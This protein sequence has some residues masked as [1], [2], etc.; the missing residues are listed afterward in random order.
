[1]T[2]QVL[3]K[4]T[5]MATLGLTLCLAYLKLDRFRYRQ[6]IQGRVQ[7]IL[8]KLQ[9]PQE[10]I[11]EPCEDTVYHLALNLLANWSNQQEF[12]KIKNSM[13]ERVKYRSLFGWQIVLYRVLFEPP[14]PRST[15]S[16]PN[17]R[18]LGCPGLDR[19]VVTLL[20]FFSLV[21]F[22]FGMAHHFIIGWDILAYV[23]DDR[24][25]FAWWIILLICILFPIIFAPIGDFALRGI[26]RDIE[27]IDAEVEK[28]SREM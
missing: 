17:S 2:D 23:F 13:K 15:W 26:K 22:V 7:K 21:F 18:F 9:L 20:F 5:P 12:R 14:L 24:F 1:M 27:H 3:F 28:F 8:T 19:L 10:G 25:Q 6:T 16:N 4:L 11:A